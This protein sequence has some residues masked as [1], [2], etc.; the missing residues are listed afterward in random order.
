MTNADGPKVR[1]G[2]KVVLEE[3]DINAAET[4]YVEVCVVIAII[5]L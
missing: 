2:K 1:I 5:E 4:Q 3:R